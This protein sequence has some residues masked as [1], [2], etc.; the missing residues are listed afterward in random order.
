[1]REIEG[2]MTY[3]VEYISPKGTFL[4]KEFNTEKE[5]DV[6]YKKKLKEMNCGDKERN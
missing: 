4:I 3:G 2:R 5:R 6:F 1:M